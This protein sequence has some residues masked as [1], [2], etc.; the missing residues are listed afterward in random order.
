[1]KIFSLTILLTTLLITPA[2]NS[3]ELRFT[4]EEL[5]R[6]KKGELSNLEKAAF[7]ELQHIS[8][9]EKTSRWPWSEPKVEPTVEPV[10]E[11]KNSFKLIDVLKL[12]TILGNRVFG[13][14]MAVKQTASAL[15]SYQAGINN[16]EKPIATFLYVGPTGVGKTELAKALAKEILHKPDQFIRLNMSEFADW[17]TGISR[18]IGITHGYVDSEKGGQLSNAILENPYSI[19]LLDE[20]EKAHDKVRKLFLHIFD[21]GYFTSGRGVVVDCTHCIFIST[22]NIGYETLLEA[23]D[24]GLSYEEIC[25]AIEPELMTALSP[26]LYNRV[27]PVMFQKL[28]KGM[29]VSIIGARLQELSKLVLDRKNVTLSFDK[30][31]GKF[32]EDKCHTMD[33]GARPVNRIIKNDITLAVAKALIQDNYGKGDKMM[34]S[35]DGTYIIV[36]KL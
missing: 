25:R 27:D 18:L 7:D 13:Q 24:Y 2:I 5:C 31:V 17:D 28:D 35:C 6:Y 34:I 14:E 10:D 9:D 8:L 15:I 19:V 26:E 16:P 20:I 3:S 1:M 21:E 30:T 23:H 36:K 32:I 33:L 12:E 4:T 11:T 22:T 29:L